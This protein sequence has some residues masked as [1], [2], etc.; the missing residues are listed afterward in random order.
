MDSERWPET[1]RKFVDD[2]VCPRCGQTKH[3]GKGV[4]VTVGYLCPV[5][6]VNSRCLRC[7]QGWFWNLAPNSEQGAEQ[8]S[9]RPVATLGTFTA[10]ASPVE[11]PDWYTHVETGEP[12]NES[13]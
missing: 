12:R 7:H 10:Q 4:L 8:L 3:E 1:I 6:T 9:P 5:W 11:K 2:I 13:R